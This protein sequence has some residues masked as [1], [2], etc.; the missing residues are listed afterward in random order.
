MYLASRLL[1]FGV[2]VGGNNQWLRARCEWVV[3]KAQYDIF[4]FVL[5]NVRCSV[6]DAVTA[7]K[8]AKEKE[9]KVV[10]K[11]PKAKRIDEVFNFEG[12]PKNLS[13]EMHIFWQIEDTTGIYRF[14]RNIKTVEDAE[15]GMIAA[16]APTGLA[17]FERVKAFEHVVTKLHGMCS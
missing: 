1:V 2:L 15:K 3:R 6:S 13:N 17:Q 12:L 7:A 10:V 4:C 11:A 14:N 5:H 16:M 9:K 8:P